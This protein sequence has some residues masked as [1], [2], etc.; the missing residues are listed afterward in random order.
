MVA[1]S[2]AIL[3]GAVGGVAAPPL[4]SAINLGELVTID[5][6][7]RGIVQ[8]ARYKNATNEN[9]RK[10]D[11]KTR[12]AAIV[13][14]EIDV[15]PTPHGAFWARLRSAGGNALNDVGGIEL[16]PCNGPLEDDVRAINGSGRNYL[17]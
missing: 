1:R 3:V 8:H 12:G 2:I 16:P 6:A 15:S 7:A 5:G 14:L 11:R 9:G 13:D 10:L 17:L 4:A